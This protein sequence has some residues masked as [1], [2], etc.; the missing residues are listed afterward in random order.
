MKKLILRCSYVFV[1]TLTSAALHG[2]ENNKQSSTSNLDIENDLFDAKALMQR[3]K[4]LSYAVF[5][6]RSALLK[7]M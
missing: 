7:K 5:M 4:F 1:I 3:V 6:S 2:Q